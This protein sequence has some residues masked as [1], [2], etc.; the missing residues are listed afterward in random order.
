MNGDYS[1][2][3]YLNNHQ[4]IETKQFYQNIAATNFELHSPPESM[5]KY[6]YIFSQKFR[7]ALPFSQIQEK[8]RLKRGK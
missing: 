2:K 5:E 7:F 3:Y 4:T 1:N 6:S 8:L